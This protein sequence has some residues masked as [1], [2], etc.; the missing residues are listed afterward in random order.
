M[1]AINDSIFGPDRP[2][3]QYRRRQTIERSV[4][5]IFGFDDSGSRIDPNM[6]GIAGYLGPRKAVEVVF[7]LL[8]RLEYRGYDSAGIALLNGGLN[9]YKK[10]GKSDGITKR[11][12]RVTLQ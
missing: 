2:R 11:N 8:K 3:P 4:P 6:C 1:C 7:D 12:S 10:K 9:V 5:K